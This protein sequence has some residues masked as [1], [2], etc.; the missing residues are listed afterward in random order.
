MPSTGSRISLMM[1]SRALAYTAKNFR[2]YSKKLNSHNKILKK[3]QHT[4]MVL[5]LGES[6][7]ITMEFMQQSASNAKSV[8]QLVCL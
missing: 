5:A 2:I 8:E 6:H 3:W 7:P 4:C 1:D